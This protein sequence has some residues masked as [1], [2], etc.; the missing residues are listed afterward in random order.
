MET[1]TVILNKK[2]TT[3]VNDDDKIVILVNGVEYGPKKQR[4]KHIQPMLN[5]LSKQYIDNC[6]W[7]SIGLMFA[8]LFM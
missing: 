8:L 4:P 7:F 1:A 3:L 2:V 6:I 5:E